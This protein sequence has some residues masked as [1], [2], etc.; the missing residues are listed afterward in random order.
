MPAAKKPSAPDTGSARA[1]RVVTTTGTHVGNA[2]LLPNGWVLWSEDGKTGWR[3][4]PAAVMVVIDWLD[5]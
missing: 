1:A 5:E 4:W 2:L 3:S